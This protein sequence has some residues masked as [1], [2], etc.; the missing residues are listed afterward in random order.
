[1]CWQLE[2]PMIDVTTVTANC[3][4]GVKDY[5]VCDRCYFTG[6]QDVVRLILF[7]VV[8]GAREPTCKYEDH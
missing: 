4:A 8:H 5:H 3:N 1:M 7:V 2:L 6:S